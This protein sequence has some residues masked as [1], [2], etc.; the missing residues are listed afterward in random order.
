MVLK[1]GQQR[2]GEPAPEKRPMEY[3]TTDLLDGLKKIQSVLDW[4]FDSTEAR[5]N[6]TVWV[7]N[8]I[9]ALLRGEKIELPKRGR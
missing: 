9:D 2:K 8:S 5:Q 1:A 7:K 6:Q 3:A 4:A